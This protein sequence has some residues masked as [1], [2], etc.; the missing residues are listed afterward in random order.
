MLNL[1]R[2]P[3]KRPARIE[4]VNKHHVYGRRINPAPRRPALREELLPHPRRAG[5]PPA[6]VANFVLLPLT[7]KP[8]APRTTAPRRLPRRGTM[9]WPNGGAGNGKGVVFAKKGDR[10][11]SP[12]PP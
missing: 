10:A 2:G 9:I 3:K 5:G 12:P 8:A 4:L 11:S 1:Q 7:A 6:D